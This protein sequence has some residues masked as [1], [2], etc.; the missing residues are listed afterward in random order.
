MLDLFY[1]FVLMGIMTVLVS[2]YCLATCTLH[3][4]INSSA[5]SL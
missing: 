5:S 2:T 4:N 3:S 1:T